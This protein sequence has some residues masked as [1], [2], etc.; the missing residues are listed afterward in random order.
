[1]PPRQNPKPLSRPRRPPATTPDAREQQMIDLAV[2]RAEEQLLDGTASAQVITHYL[3][4]ATAREK[5]EQEKLRQEITLRAAKTAQ[6]ESSTRA[7]ELYE[8]AIK[9][10][11]VY[12]GNLTGGDD[13]D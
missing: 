4:L 3:K 7:E 10:M 6:I 5:L 12:Q 11:G 8:A 13:H 9:A 1:M 2:A